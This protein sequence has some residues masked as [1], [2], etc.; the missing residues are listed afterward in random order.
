MIANFSTVLTLS[1]MVACGDSKDDTADT[2]DASVGS[3]GDS[4]ADAD[5][6]ADAHSDLVGIGFNSE[7]QTYE[8]RAVNTDPLEVTVVA[9]IAFSDGG[10]ATAPGVLSDSKGGM[11]YA[12]T[13]N[14]T[15]YGF[16]MDG[17]SAE[18][19]GPLGGTLQHVDMGI[20]SLI[21]IGY[22]PMSGKNVLRSVD[23]ETAAVSDLTDFTFDSD[24]WYGYVVNDPENGVVYAVSGN[25]TLFRL[26]MDG[27][28]VEEVGTLS[29]GIQHMGLGTDGLIGVGYNESTGLNE[30]RSVN[31]ETAEV[32]TLTSFAFDTGSWQA[33]VVTDPEA[34]VFYAWSDVLTTYRLQMDGS[35][36]ESVGSAPGDMLGIDL[37]AR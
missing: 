18:E 17:S 7:R 22:N 14:A 33:W 2:A 1:L 30:V 16:A 25:D 12:F 37:G 36:V 27:S 6:D 26:Q 3:G 29:K 34:G 19:I 4:D 8:L 9:D 31:T 20:D 24:W 15:L 13:D 5:A 21:G 23:L 28:A 10:F 32:T 35:A 11:V